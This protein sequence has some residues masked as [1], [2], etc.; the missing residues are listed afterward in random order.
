MDV[1]KINPTSS[2]IKYDPRHQQFT[3]QP[4]WQHGFDQTKRGQTDIIQVVDWGLDSKTLL[5]AWRPSI[6]HLGI[7]KTIPVI[8]DVDTRQASRR[9]YLP[10]RIWDDFL[11]RHPSLKIAIWFGTWCRW[12]LTRPGPQARFYSGWYSSAG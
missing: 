8:Y 3:R 5:M 6:L 12:V 7:R 11:A 1:S 9:L 10:Q 4:V 2:G